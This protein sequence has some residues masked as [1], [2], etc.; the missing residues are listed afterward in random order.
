MKIQELSI[1]ERILLAEELWDSVMVEQGLLPI[2]EEQRKEL[3][4]RLEM[5]EAS[6]SP[7]APWSEVLQKL[8]TL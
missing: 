7:G 4:R 6:S 5:Y 2:S 3:D 8:R 1:S